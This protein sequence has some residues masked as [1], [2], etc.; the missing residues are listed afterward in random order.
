M[1]H[2]EIN[3]IRGR[4]I[5]KTARQGLFWGTLG[6]LVLCCIGLAIVTHRATLRMVDATEQRREMKIIERQFNADYPEADSVLSYVQ[7]MRS[8]MGLAADVL[9]GIDATIR[10]RVSLPRIL[11]GLARPLPPESVLVNVDL[12]RKD[13]T[14]QFGVMTP[15]GGSRMLTAGEIIN[16]WNRDGTLA[17]QLREIRAETSQRQYRSGRPVL[18]HRFSAALATRSGGA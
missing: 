6:Y 5:N 9:T 18:V 2:F 10:N 7:G 14:V 15:T 11:L 16:L 3:L 17:A 1:V 4:V 13:G 8:E 12:Q